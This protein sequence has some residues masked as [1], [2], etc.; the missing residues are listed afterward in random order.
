MGR[1]Q[2]LSG[3]DVLLVSDEASDTGELKSGLKDSGAVQINEASVGD[4][5]LQV[6]GKTSVDLIVLEVEKPTLDLFEKFAIVHEYCP[7]PVVCFSA[8]RD[9]KIIAKSV[10]AGVSAYIVDGKNAERIKPI[11]D[12]AMLRFSECQA[13]RKELAQVKD[14]LSERAVIEK[15]KGLLIEHKNMTEDQAYRAM[16]KMAMDQ[17]KKISVIA[18]EVCDVISGILKHESVN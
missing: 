11:V 14:K 10:K 9:S 16:R 13:V 18:K 17:G 1:M 12:V 5:L 2:M 4:N 7:K 3:F 15:A 6:L 8:E